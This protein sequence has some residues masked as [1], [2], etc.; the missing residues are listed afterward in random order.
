MIASAMLPPPMK[1]HFPVVVTV[2]FPMASLRED[3]KNID[4]RSYLYLLLQFLPEHF[5][6]SSRGVTA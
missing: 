4:I 2:L 1:P 5:L 3:S 6:R